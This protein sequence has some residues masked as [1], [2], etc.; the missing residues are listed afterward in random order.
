MAVRTVVLAHAGSGDP[1]TITTVYTCPQ[2]RTAICKDIRFYAEFGASSRAIIL[3]RSGPLNVS[4]FDG[5]MS[6]LE[7]KHLDCWIALE[8]GHQICL[9]SKEFSIWAWLSGTEL[10]GVAP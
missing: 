6:M 1:N 3:V 9:Y 5:P 8:P 7:A 10:D 4:L 2:G